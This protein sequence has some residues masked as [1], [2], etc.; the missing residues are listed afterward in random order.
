M[1]EEELKRLIEKYYN[2]E[3]TEEEEKALRIFFRYGNVPRGYEAEKEIFGFFDES[4]QIPEPSVDFESRL[5][6]GID[7]IE[8]RRSGTLRRFLIPALSTAA[9]LM[10]LAGSYFLFTN[11]SGSQDTFK[12]PEIAYMET[13]KILRVVSVRMNRGAQA[14]EPVGKMNEASKKGFETFARSARIVEKN[15]K[16]LNHLQDPANFNSN[17]V[18]KNINK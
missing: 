9:G 15:L 8:G 18:E 16:S 17:Q 7:A 4:V 10:L 6:A 3:S 11:R 1:K 2:G 13:M 12:D 5:L 14:L